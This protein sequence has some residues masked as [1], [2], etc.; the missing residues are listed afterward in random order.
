MRQK[1]FAIP[2][3]ILVIVILVGAGVF[4]A[5]Y[6]GTD[7]LLS[8]TLSTPSQSPPSETQAI[9][10]VKRDPE[11]VDWLKLFNGPG[12]TSPKTGGKPSFMNE[13]L[14]DGSYSIR[15][16]ENSRE[17]IATFGFYSVNSLTGEVRKE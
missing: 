7:K 17:N 10:L 2:V 12:G 1:G 6:K 15:V 3:F 5:N 13:G 16:F 11:V 9:E 4:V 14:K 8:E